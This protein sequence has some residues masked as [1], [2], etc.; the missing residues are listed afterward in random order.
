MKKILN[1]CKYLRLIANNL[2]IRLLPVSKMPPARY[3]LSL[4][5]IF[6]NE[7]KYMKEWLDFHLIVGFE[8]F[9]LYNNFSSDNYWE[10]LKPYIEKGLVTLI[11]WPY[12]HGQMAAYN[13]CV[14]KFKNESN[15][16]AF[17]DLDE[18]AV[19]LAYDDVK[20]WLKNY[21]KFPCVLGFFKD[22][23]SSGRMKDDESKPVIEQFVVCSDFVSPSMF[24]N[25]AWAGRIKEFRLSHFCR[26][27][28][29]NKVCPE[30]AGF[31]CRWHE[32]PR[33]LDF[34][35][36]H[37]HSKSFDY[38][39]SKK[40]PGGDAFSAQNSYSL[41]HFYKNEQKCGKVDYNAYRYLIKLKNFNLDDYQA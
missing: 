14:D 20:A 8:H 5:S 31:L 30:N 28:F 33:K 40:I 18:F 37:Y 3:Y 15:W 24:L 2:I 19:P 1:F 11:E 22:F 38:Y 7:G 41:N 16:I 27:K 21:E 4:C 10:I 17:M 36:N 6:K 34:Q 32:Q 29:F 12:Q 35:F 25:T 23:S 13:D 9:Y 39:V 26:F